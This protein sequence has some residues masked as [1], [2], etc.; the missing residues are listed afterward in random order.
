MDAANGNVTQ[1]GGAVCGFDRAESRF[2]DISGELRNG[3]EEGGR[4]AERGNGNG[5]AQG[6]EG[7]GRTG[8][9]SERESCRSYRQENSSGRG[10]MGSSSR[11]DVH[12]NNL[13]ISLMGLRGIANV[14]EGLF[15][16]GEESEEEKREREARNAGTAAGVVAG[17]ITGIAIRHHQ[18]HEPDIENNDDE[19]EAP[20][21]GMTM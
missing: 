3:D 5:S 18:N 16:D 6:D 2:E 12:P 19:D 9:E 11:T 20:K 8:W 17:T 21:M 13:D 4:G 7:S 1:N 15:E 10:N 14:T